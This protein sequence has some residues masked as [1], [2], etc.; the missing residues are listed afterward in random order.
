MS[1]IRSE[2]DSFGSID[3]PAKALWGAQTARSQHFFA[4]G[5]QPCRWT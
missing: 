5:A 4:I 1:K 2:S 3:L